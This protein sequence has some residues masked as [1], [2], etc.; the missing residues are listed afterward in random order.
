MGAPARDMPAIIR[1]GARARCAQEARSSTPLAR[2]DTS[3]RGVAV[4][5]VATS[6]H[7]HLVRN[8]LRRLACALALPASLGLLAACSTSKS[9]A[10]PTTDDG[11]P[12][13][14]AAA[15][16]DAGADGATAYDF[17]AMRDYLFSG[18]WKTDGVVVLHDGQ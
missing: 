4:A 1:A 15:P 2:Q 6:R 3:P 9:D 12:T 18:A 16:G 14:E 11:G 7:N 5:R 17:S 8:L 10:N 13:A